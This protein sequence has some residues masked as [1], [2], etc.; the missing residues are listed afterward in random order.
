MENKSSELKRGVMVFVGLAILTVI[1]F[2]FGIWEVASIFL[3]IIALTKAGLVIW[4]FMHI[5]RLFG[6]D[7][8]VHS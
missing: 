2:V 4:F 7:S 8:E 6:G 1:E 3:W 5:F